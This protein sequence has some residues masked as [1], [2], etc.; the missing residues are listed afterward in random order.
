MT[1]ADEPIAIERGRR[2]DA[3]RLPSYEEIKAKLWPDVYFYD[4]QWEM[5]R[6]IDESVETYV[7]AG[8]MLGKDY[9]TGFICVASFLRHPVCRIV[10][11][12]VS[13][14]HLVVLWGEINRFIDTARYPLRDSKGG[15]L[16]VNHMFIR[17]WDP[18][19]GGRRGKRLTEEECCPISRLSGIV[20]GGDG[21]GLAGHHAPWTL[22]V[23]D[24]A[25][26]SDDKV[27]DK[28]QGWAKRLLVFGNPHPCNNFFRRGVKAGNLEA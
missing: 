23:V 13:E 19:K 15:P 14:K 3:V 21:E 28:M 24:E 16:L 7:T 9:V 5:I 22:G 27:Y 1:V 20:A 26:G 4:K 17:K 18:T 6:S 2:V 12:S 8:N 10:T 25:S 11:N